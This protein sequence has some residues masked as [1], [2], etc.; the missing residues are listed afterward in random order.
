[1]QYDILESPADL[2]RKHPELKCLGVTLCD[3]RE[4]LGIGADYD[5]AREAKEI[6]V[7]EPACPR[8]VQIM[9]RCVDFCLK[10]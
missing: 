1:M 9:A 5:V 3:D 4:C 7:T 6:L 10:K 8:D 2:I